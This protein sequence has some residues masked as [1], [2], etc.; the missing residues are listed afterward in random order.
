MSTQRPYTTDLSDDE[1]EI[2][3]PLVPKAKPGGR[4]R[5]HETRELLNAIFFLR[6]QG[7]VRLEATSP[8]LLLAL[9]DRLPLL[10]GVAHGWDLGADTHHLAREATPPGG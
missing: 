9:A 1:W 10:Q 3:E 7:R 6:A 4:P 2:L 8:R 5:V